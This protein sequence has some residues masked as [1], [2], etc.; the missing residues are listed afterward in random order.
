M[1]VWRDLSR[2]RMMRGGLEAVHLGHLDVEEDD[3]E[4]VRQ[5]PFERLAPRLRLDQVLAQALEHCLQG[6]QVGRLVVDQKNVDPVV[7]HRGSGAAGQRGGFIGCD[8]P[9]V[10][11]LARISRDHC[12]AAPLPRR[13]A[14]RYSHT[15]S[16]DSS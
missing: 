14:Y 2:W 10:A 15:R 13:P 16:S 12:P 4:L 1:G 3:G 11:R 7:G 6:H 9:L 5:E 8:N